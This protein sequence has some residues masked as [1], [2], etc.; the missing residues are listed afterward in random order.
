MPIDLNVGIIALITK[1]GD[2]TLPKNYK[3]ISLLGG[4]YKILAKLLALRIQPLLLA[5]I[6][7]SQ[8]CFIYGQDIVQNIF[9]AQ[10]AMTWAIKGKQDLALLLLDFEKAF[11]RLNW[12]FMEG[13]LQKLGFDPT[14]TG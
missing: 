1:D 5:L 3:P 13:I 6:R 11:D 7:P 2:P 14:L 10:E 8:T 4:F 9:L 12:D